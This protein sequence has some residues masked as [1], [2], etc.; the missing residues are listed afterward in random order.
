MKKYL[1]L[2]VFVFASFLLQ[3]QTQITLKEIVEKALEKNYELKNRQLRTEQ[4]R[5]DRRK[6][7][8]TYLPK[9]EASASY[10]ILNDDVRLPEDLTNLLTATQALLIK[11]RAGIPF[12]QPLETLPPQILSQLPEIQEVPPI[13]ENEILK[14]DISAQMV[15]FSGLKAPMLYKATNHQ[16]KANEL[17]SEIEKAA[18]IQDVIINYDRLAVVIK[19]EETYNNTKVYLLEQERYVNKAFSNGLATKLDLYKIELA[20]QQ[21]EAKG[22]ELNSAKQLLASRLEQLT[23]VQANIF[24]QTVPILTVWERPTFAFDAEQRND[25]QALN[26]TILAVN[27]KRK[28]E[29]CDYVP[30]VVLFGKKELLTDDLSAFDPQWYVG[31]GV[32][33]TI[34]DG[35]T[36]SSQAQKS[37]IEREILQNRKNEAV[38]LLGLKMQQLNF[39]IDKNMKLVEVAKKNVTSASEAFELSKKEYEIGLRTLSEHLEY[40][41]ELENARLQLIEAI[42]NQRV[43][44]VKYLEATNNLKIENI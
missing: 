25:I 3:S 33:W 31:I 32:R 43:S 24:Y 44:T 39:E 7:F 11:E 20:K 38:E 17:L 27:Y 4:S 35:F 26:E 6:V 41:K 16:I 2:S 15:I 22:I 40:I 10:T 29:L 9:I 8:Y 23:G 19:S 28:S 21:L 1:I 42:Y 13:Q 14:A 18:I 36:A 5:I 30:K 37:K 12:N 34:F